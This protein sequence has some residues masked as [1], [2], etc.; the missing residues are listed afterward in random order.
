MK[1]FRHFKSKHHSYF[2]VLLIKTFGVTFRVIGFAGTP[3]YLSPEV[4]RKEPYGKAVDVWACGKLLWFSIYFL[5]SGIYDL[6]FEV[7]TTQ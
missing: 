4:L 2:S 5:F 3:G 6:L 1:C 7:F